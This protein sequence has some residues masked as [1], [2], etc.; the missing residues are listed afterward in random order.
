M[1]EFIV[2]AF[3]FCK[4]GER[5]EGDLAVSELP[6]LAQETVDQ[7]GTLRWVL[8]GGRDQQGHPRLQLAI[9][10]NVELLCQRCLMPLAFTLDSTSTLVLAQ[11]EGSAD[12][13]EQ[14]LADED[15][16]V[17]VGSASMNLLHLIEDEALLALPISPR[18]DACA[19][20]AAIVEEVPEKA[21][22][23]SVLKKLKH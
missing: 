15:V 1:S 18:H 23:F 3:S 5:R 21:S 16:E 14:M 4:H 19:G 11:D 7:A 10:G 13:V 9:R 12:E 8:Q 20:G 17:I 6:R 2:D 22:P